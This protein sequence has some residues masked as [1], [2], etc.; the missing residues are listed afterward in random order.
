MTEGTVREKLRQAVMR[1]RARIYPHA[2]MLGK[3]YRHPCAICGKDSVYVLAVKVS[4][5]ERETYTRVC[6]D[7]KGATANELI[8]GEHF[9]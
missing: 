4:P 8:H 7:H 9:E 2:V 6:E 5:N 3:I 1:Q